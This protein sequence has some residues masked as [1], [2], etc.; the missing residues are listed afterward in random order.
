MKYRIRPKWATPLFCALALVATAGAALAS[1]AA[2]QPQAAAPLATSAASEGSREQRAMDRLI[3]YVG[4]SGIYAEW[5]SMECLM[6]MVEHAE[7]G[8][9][10]IAIRERHEGSC[11]GEPSVAPVVDRF[12]VPEDGPILWYDSLQSNYVDISQLQASRAQ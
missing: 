4:Q 1:G 6:L 9:Y 2:Q 5:T 10:D 8:H 3:Q 12:R 11:P 7:Q